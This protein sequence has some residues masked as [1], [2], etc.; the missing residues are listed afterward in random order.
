[1]T[2]VNLVYSFPSLLRGDEDTSRGQHPPTAK[3]SEDP[4]LPVGGVVDHLL[5]RLTAAL[6]LTQILLATEDDVE[7][8]LTPTN[9]SDPME[10]DGDQVGG[11][12]EE[13]EKREL[14]AC[15]R[16]MRVEAGYATKVRSP[17]VVM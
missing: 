6:R 17:L 1:M 7:G 15:W 14:V 13:E 11:E 3:N 12:E 4:R 16:R 9:E 10:V 8:S 5:L 2:L